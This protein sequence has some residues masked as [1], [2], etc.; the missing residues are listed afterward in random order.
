[1][2]QELVSL[3]WSM[4]ILFFIALTALLGAN[5]YEE[6]IQRNFKKDFTWAQKYI[7]RIVGG[8]YIPLLCIFSPSREEVMFRA[9]LI[10]LS[11]LFHQNFL[12]CGIAVLVSSVLFAKGHKVEN[13]MIFGAS[14]L[15]F[16]N[17]LWLYIQTF[18]IGILF[19][20]V[21]IW[22]QSLYPVV[23]LHAALNFYVCVHNMVILY[24]IPR[25]LDRISTL[26]DALSRR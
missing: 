18:V 3:C 21:S 13:Q 20:W 14:T 24:L 4:I 10:L 26:M 15:V 11:I 17:Q 23:L 12:L 2:Y 6:R 7:A 16:Q 19:S 8:Y 22:Y 5:E 25:I 9:P 1:M